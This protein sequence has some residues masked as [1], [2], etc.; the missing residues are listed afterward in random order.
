MNCPIYKAAAIAFQGFV[1]NID[2]TCDKGECASFHPTTQS[3]EVSR[4]ASVLS[5]IA[6]YLDPLVDKIPTATQTAAD[7]IKQYNGLSGEEQAL[8]KGLF[9]F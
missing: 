8:F 9:L 1:G 6:N 2:V 4:I 7:L 3:C 5:T